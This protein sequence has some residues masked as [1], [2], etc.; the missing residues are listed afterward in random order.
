VQNNLGLVGFKIFVGILLTKMYVWPDGG[1]MSQR[2]PRYHLIKVSSTEIALLFY[3]VNAEDY[4]H[5]NESL[6]QTTP[7]C[8]Q[9]LWKEREVIELSEITH[10]QLHGVR[11][12]ACDSSQS[13][14]KV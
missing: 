11:Q 5:V 14:K 7:A 6:G 12:N 2:H 13:Y 3:S 10:Y 1:I 8:C 9:T 4:T